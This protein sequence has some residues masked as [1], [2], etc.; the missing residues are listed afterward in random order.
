[1]ASNAFA[2]PSSRD[3]TFEFSGRVITCELTS[4]P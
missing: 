1:L 3:D 2:I 4:V